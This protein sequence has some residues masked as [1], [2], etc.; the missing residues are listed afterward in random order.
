[1]H[2]DTPADAPNWPAPHTAHTVADAD[3]YWPAA[4]EPEVTES[5][6]AAQ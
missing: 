4:H 6:A 3:E 2:A 1:V 5:P